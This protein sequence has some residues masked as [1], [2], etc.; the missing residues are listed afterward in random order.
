[1]QTLVSLSQLLS[2]V[3]RTHVD[4]GLAA[5]Q[6]RAEHNLLTMDVER[7]ATLIAT[8][9]RAMRRLDVE[10]SVIVERRLMEGA[11]I[12]PP[13][14]AV[15]KLDTALALLAVRG[16]MRWILVAS[17]W[18]WHETQHALAVFGTLFRSAI[19]SET[20]VELGSESKR[21]VVRLRCRPELSARLTLERAG[22]KSIASE[23]ESSQG[24]EYE[25]IAR[26]GR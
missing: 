5:M 19:Q 26:S 14:S 7:R 21:C 22:L 16:H 17:G 1:M 13:S 9:V 2:D 12:R 3:E 25:C 8:F 18:T 11:K 10:T 15:F 23:R 20:S 4:E 24:L 6:S